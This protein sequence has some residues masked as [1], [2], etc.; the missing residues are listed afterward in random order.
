MKLNL[1]GPQ[2][3]PVVQRLSV[4]G[5]PPKP[6][7]HQFIDNQNWIK[8]ITSDATCWQLPRESLRDSGPLTLKSVY[9]LLD[10]GTRPTNPLWK[11]K[12]WFERCKQGG[13]WRGISVRI[14]MNNWFMRSSYFYLKSTN[15]CFFFLI[16]AFSSTFKFNMTSSSQI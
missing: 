6:S 9:L 4:G 13:W 14:C 1:W 8:S 12:R 16:R 15:K 11:K 10:C 2:V 7:T 3:C 5:R